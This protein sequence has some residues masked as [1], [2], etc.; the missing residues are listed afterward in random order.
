MF[1]KYGNPKFA[2]EKLEEF[3]AA[4]REKYA[5]TLLES[6]L[7]LVLRKKT[8]FI[9]SKALNFAI[10]YV[11]QSTKMPLTMNKLKPFVEKLLYD[12]IVAPIM[13]I[14]HRDVTLFKEDP[15][16]YVRK[17]N[18]FTE[19]LFAPKN[20]AVDLLLYLCKYKST[21]K[22]K[23]PDY[24]EGFLQFCAKNL[25]QYSQAVATGQALD[26]RVKESI[27]YAIGSLFEEI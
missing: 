19:T 8:N 11:G 20:T 7:S 21:K 12:V 24:L 23:Q 22:S 27:L 2:D 1:S 3:S 13:L 15:I 6:H 10:K 4:F 18:D 9:G 17:Q 5:V 16:E 26:W 25:Q 14:T